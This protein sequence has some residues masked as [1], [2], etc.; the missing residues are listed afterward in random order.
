[1]VTSAWSGCK[2]RD[3]S[4]PACSCP[5]RADVELGLSAIARGGPE[6]VVLLVECGQCA[7]VKKKP[8]N[9]GGGGGGSGN[10]AAAPGQQFR[11][12]ACRPTQG[13]CGFRVSVR[14]AAAP[15][16]KGR[17]LFAREAIPAG[18]FVLEYA[19][20]ALSS[21][22]AAAQLRAYDEARR[23]WRRRAEEG[24][25]DDAGEEEPGGASGHALLKIVVHGRMTP[26]GAVAAG[27][28]RLCASIDATRRGNAARF[29]NHSCDP[30]L[31]AVLVRNRRSSDVNDAASHAAVPF[32]VALFSRRAVAVGQELTMSYGD[33]GGG[34]GGGGASRCECG[35]AACDGWL[36]SGGAAF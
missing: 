16:S 6:A 10:D 8:R 5:C 12:L 30:N 36:P 20:E 29:V 11:R 26:I 2:C 21:E 14:A 3:C 31:G 24:E 27:P 18:A 4:S 32:R 13:G 34:G 23:R 28:Y 1:M 7:C 17:G 25:Q 35:A 33:G 9:A 22:A 15:G 19:G